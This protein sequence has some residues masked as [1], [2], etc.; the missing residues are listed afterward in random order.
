MVQLLS[1]KGADKEAFYNEKSTPEH[2]AAH[3]NRVASALAL[4]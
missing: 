3:A 2:L 1:F 4:L